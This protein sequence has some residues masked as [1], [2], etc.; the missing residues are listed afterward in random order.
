MRDQ[1]RARVYAAEHQVQATLDRAQRGAGTVDFFGSVLTLPVEHRFGDLESIQ[2]YV[3]A[4]LDLDWVTA[5]WPGLPPVRVR[6]RRGTTRAH[7][8]TPDTIAI[9]DQAQ[10]ALRALVADHEIAHHLVAHHPN[11]PQQTAHGPLFTATMVGLV[12]TAIGPEVGLLLRAA[13]DGAGV[14]VG[15]DP[16]PVA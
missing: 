4:V 16:A 3:D 12:S 14:P 10:W 1:H 11:G 9:P 15:P 2:R 6:R 13:Y 5:R 8:E 7:Y